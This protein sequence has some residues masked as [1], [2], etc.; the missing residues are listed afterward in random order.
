MEIYFSNRYHFTIEKCASNCKSMKSNQELKIPIHLYTSNEFAEK[1]F[2]IFG[3]GKQHALL[4]YKEWFRTGCVKGEN[5]AFNNAKALF[6][7][8][9]A[10]TDFSLPP[11]LK[12]LDEEKTGKILI[13]TSDGFEIESV[14]LPMK[15]G[16]TLCLSSQIGCKMGCA[17]C[18]TAKMGLKRN[19][20]ASEIVTQLFHAKHTLNVPIRNLVFMGMGEPLDNFE[21]VMK[22]IAI[23][24]DFNGFGLGESRITVSTSGLCDQI[25]RFIEKAPSAVHLAVSVNAPNDQVRSKLMPVNKKYDMQALKES[26]LKYCLQ[27]KRKILVEYVLIA[28]KNDSLQDAVTLAD[29]LEGLDVTVNLIPYN[30]GRRGTFKPASEKNIDEFAT[31]L[32]QKGYLVFVRTTRGQKIM[33][34]C[35]QL[36]NRKSQALP[37]YY[38]Y[39]MVENSKNE[40][41]D[42]T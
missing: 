34:A 22:S 3:K 6:E 7:D 13:A 2:S 35:G 33:A 38:P 9:L 29:Y 21:E 18:E 28:E 31:H 8:I 14:V 10:I 1:I 26:M 39:S 23:I 37:F 32:K 15:A 11:L 30:P 5:P 25:E 42:G 20:S 16:Y 24:T 17:F 4:I 41:N 19:L 27:R 36:G 40:V 12:K